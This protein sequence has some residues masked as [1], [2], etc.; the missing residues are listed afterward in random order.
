MREL[1]R[2][3][4][5]ELILFSVVYALLVWIFYSVAGKPIDFFIVFLGLI[6]ALIFAG[7]NVLTIYSLLKPKLKFLESDEKNVPAFG[8]KVEKVFVVERSDFSFEATKYKIKEHYQITLFDDA[9]QYLIKFH[10]RISLFS[11]GVAGT[12]AYDSVTKTITQTCFPIHAHTDKAVKS[13]QA[14]FDKVESLVVNK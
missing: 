12:V 9:E 7:I 5:V 14:M 13:T 4:V 10:S 6:A 1:K 3:F 2:I 11:W 8:D